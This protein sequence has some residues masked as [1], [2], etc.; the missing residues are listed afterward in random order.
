MVIVKE[1]VMLF[2]DVYGNIISA[3]YIVSSVN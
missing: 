3:A 1:M 2:Y